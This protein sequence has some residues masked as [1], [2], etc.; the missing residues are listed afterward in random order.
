MRISDENARVWSGLEPSDADEEAITRLSLDLLDARKQIAEQA[1]ELSLCRELRDA[2]QGIAVDAGVVITDDPIEDVRL[3]IEF[4]DTE[5][6]EQ[7]REIEGLKG[8]GRGP[9]G[10]HD[11]SDL[12]APDPEDEPIEKQ[13]ER[14]RTARQK[15]ER[16]RDGARD[17]VHEWATKHGE[18]NAQLEEA[19]DDQN[20]GTD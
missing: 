20:S 7:A 3:A 10:Y 4:R 13:L 11:I 6:A 8:P 5:I 19:R 17:L 14:E 1:K 12:Y 15:A 16:E 18:L 9:K 2:V